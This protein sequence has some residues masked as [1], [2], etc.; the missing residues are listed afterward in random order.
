MGSTGATDE[1]ADGSGTQPVYGCKWLAPHET[2]D[3]RAS[4]KEGFSADVMQAQCRPLRLL[5]L[6]VLVHAVVLPGVLHAY[7]SSPVLS[8]LEPGAQ[9]PP[10]LADRV[11]VVVADGLRADTC[12]NF[13]KANTRSFLAGASHTGVSLVSVSQAPTESRPGHVAI[14]AG[15]FEDVSAITLVSSIRMMCSNSL[16]AIAGLAR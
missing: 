12:S 11:V 2:R 13:L 16:T 15:I 1:R 5:L 7:F 4:R 9:M 8:G 3:H 14:F 6:G 10:P